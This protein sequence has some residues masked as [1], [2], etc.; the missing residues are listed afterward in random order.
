[1]ASA[2]AGAAQVDLAGGVLA[3]LAAWLLIPED[4]TG[5]RIEIGWRLSRAAWG[6]GYAPEAAARILH[7]AFE[8]LDLSEVVAEID[9]RNERSIRVAER[10]GMRRTHPAPQR[11]A[12]AYRL[13]AADF[14]RRPG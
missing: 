11:F 4:A 10:I 8:T 5:P 13:A 9:A 3:Y 14:A 2:R 1:M 7:H 12:V 6:Y